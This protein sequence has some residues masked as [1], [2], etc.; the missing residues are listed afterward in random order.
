M[1]IFTSQ[2]LYLIDR[3]YIYFT[4]YCIYIYTSNCVYWVDVSTAYVHIGCSVICLFK[5][6][7][8]GQKFV[9]CF[10]FFYIKNIA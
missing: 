3:E 8:Y 4:N 1:Y 6:I 9:E 10:L 2:S 7:I 5:N